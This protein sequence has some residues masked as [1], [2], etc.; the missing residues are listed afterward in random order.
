MNPYTVATGT[1]HMNPYT[2]ATGMLRGTTWPK[3]AASVTVSRI[4]SCGIWPALPLTGYWLVPSGSLRGGET[5]SSALGLFALWTMAGIILWSICLLSTAAARVYR[6]TYFGL[7]GWVVS[8]ASLA[9]LAG[10]DRLVF[11][12]VGS[13]TAWDWALFACLA[14][15]ALLYLGFPRETLLEANDMGVYANHGVFIAR[16]GRLDLPYPWLGV[17]PTLAGELMAHAPYKSPFFRNHVFLGFQKN[18]AGI[19]AEFG[20]VWPVWL[21]QAF[22]SAGPAGLFRLNGV[23]ALLAAAAF[24]GLC[25]IAMPAPLAV[26]ATAFLV[27]SPS[28]VWIARTTLSEVFTQLACCSGVLLLLEASKSGTP[29][30]ALWAG[31]MLSFAALIRCDGFLLIPLALAAQLGQ[32]LVGPSAGRLD[33]V[34][35]SFWGS[36]GPG[37]LVAAGYY[38]GFSRPYFWKQFFYLRLIGLAAALACLALL[39]LPP[40]LSGDA[41]IWLRSGPAADLSGGGV[42][43]LAAYAYWIRPA[44]VHYRLDWPEHPL[45]GE[46]HRAEYSL[47]DLCRYVSPVVLVAAVAGGWL[48]LR[49]CTGLTIPWLLPWLMIVGGYAG[50]Y[51]YDPCDDPWHFWRVRRYVPVVIPGFLFF[52][53]VAVAYG[54]D[55][56]PEAGRRPASAALLASL[57]GFNA[58]RGARFWRRSEDAGAW[59]Q[60]RALADLIPPGVPVFAA[61]RPEWMTPLHVAFDRRILPLDLDQDAGWELLA[62]GVAAQV[63]RG[64]PAFLL[65]DKRYTFSRQPRE[66]GRV[67]LFRR[68]I[69]STPSPIPRRFKEVQTTVVLAAFSGPLEP[70]KSH[71]IAMGATRVWGVEESGF[72]DEAACFDQPR[73]WTN[74]HGKLLVPLADG[75]VPDRLMID[76]AWVGPAGTRL[77]I[78]ANGHE[79]HSGP[80]RCR[81]GW[82][83]TLPLAGVPIGPELTIELISDTFQPDQCIEGSADTRN[84]GVLVRELRLLTRG[85]NHRDGCD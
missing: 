74:G 39:L 51:L 35:F 21:A 67:V 47:R 77:Q 83:K 9:A 66:I 15:A 46:P 6:S 27:L 19:T 72:H 45:H 85:S 42:A 79:L 14:L 76:L 68:F 11:P 58:W 44:V 81:R 84:L 2:L 63:S 28:Q 43:L 36:A 13:C 59:D 57:I 40:L 69:E 65:Y 8:V 32:S 50:L 12:A 41:R 25:L 64:E 60:L 20:H 4:V 16:H 5:P 53:A 38:V 71:L 82:C 30:L 62:R 29:V 55:L 1:G 49:E 22:A 48:A 10:A 17:D 78:L 52:A 7:A 33:P 34:W 18:G 70:P 73:R 31:G 61:G 56:V 75:G 37:F 24:H 54:L 80:L 23:F 26:L 3:A